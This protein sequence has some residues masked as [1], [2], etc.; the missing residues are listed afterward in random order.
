[1]EEKNIMNNE[2][3]GAGRDAP[4]AK[5]EFLIGQKLTMTDV[6]RSRME[7]RDRMVDDFDF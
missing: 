7:K 2:R 6:W 4:I 3:E 1:M 5:K